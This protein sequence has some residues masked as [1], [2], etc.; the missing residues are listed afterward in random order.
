MREA[1]RMATIG[2]ITTS[3]S[4][5]IRNP[6]SAIK[7][8][9]QVIKKNEKLEGNDRRR[10]D[11]SVQ[12]VKRLEGILQELLDFA[13]PLTL[14]LK[15]SHINSIVA[16]CL[17]LLE[18]KFKEKEI[19]VSLN[20]DQAL[21]RIVFDPGK[22]RQA[23]MNLVINAI[24]ASPVNGAIKLET[25]FI[26]DEHRAEALVCVRDEGRVFFKKIFPNW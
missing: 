19:N 22:F 9:L 13:K 11:I 2:Q 8:N 12:E 7:L 24:E 1:E 26:K 5:E 4:H 17:E 3:L 10:I 23:I 15:S 18:I 14:N 25:R 21:P 20:L 16:Q 6:L